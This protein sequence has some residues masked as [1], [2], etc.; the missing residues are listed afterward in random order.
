[1]AV[2]WL[3]HPSM[4]RQLVCCRLCHGEGYGSAVLGLGCYVTGVCVP[5]KA[6]GEDTSSTDERQRPSHH[7]TLEPAVVPWTSSCR[8]HPT[9]AVGSWC[10][11]IGALFSCLHISRG[12]VSEMF[13]RGL[14]SCAAEVAVLSLDSRFQMGCSKGIM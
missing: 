7:L 3:R 13:V 10:G 8:L 9:V 1:M 5:H 11:N 12:P 4:Q 6:C 2:S 14:L